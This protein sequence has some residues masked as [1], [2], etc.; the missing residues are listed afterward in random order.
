MS[1]PIYRLNI[2]TSLHFKWNARLDPGNVWVLNFHQLWGGTAGI[3]PMYED[4]EKIRCELLEDFNVLS[5]RL[6]GREANNKFKLND[7][8]SLMFRLKFCGEV[9]AHV[10]D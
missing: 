8:Q 3:A 5:V 10:P 6:L 4:F 1:N 9:I 7:K 2:V